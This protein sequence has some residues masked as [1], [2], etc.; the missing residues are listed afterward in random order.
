MVT[1][2]SALLK[3]VKSVEDEAGRGVRLLESTIDRIDAEIK[4]I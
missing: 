3:T 4:V 2:V 1:K